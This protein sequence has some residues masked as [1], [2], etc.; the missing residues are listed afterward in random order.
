MLAASVEIDRAAVAGLESLLGRVAKETPRRLATETRRAALYVCQALRKRTR[1][2]PKRIRRGEYSAAPSPLPPRYVHSHSAGHPLLRRWRL[3]RK[4]GTPHE[5]A[6]DYFVHTGARRGKGGRM[7]GKSQSAERSELLRL[8]GGIRRR[9][10]AKKSWGWIA[11]RIYS[12]F[13]AVDLA[14]RRSGGERRDPLKAVDGAFRASAAGAVALIRNHLD[15]IAAALRPGAVSES[16][17]AATRRLEH[18]IERLLERAM[19]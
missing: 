15:Y 12:A 7:V 1:Q 10:L 19:K 11:K 3:V 6:K 17:A 18:N 5:Y 16:V 4:A 9:G 13:A 2:A 14:W 8:H